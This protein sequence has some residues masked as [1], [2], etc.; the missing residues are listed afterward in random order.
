M[1]AKNLRNIK[2]FGKMD[3]YIVLKVRNDMFQTSPD[4]DGHTE[5]IWKETLNLPI[6]SF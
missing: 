3:P 4:Q 2:F 5:P 6:Y 1:S